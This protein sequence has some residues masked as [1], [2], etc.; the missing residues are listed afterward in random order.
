[1]LIFLNCYINFDYKCSIYNCYGDGNRDRDR[2][3]GRDRDRDRETERQRYRETDRQRDRETETERQRDRETERQRDRGTERQRNR[4][5]ERLTDRE[6]ERQTHTDRE[7]HRQTGR[8]RDR[9]TDR[10]THRQ[11]DRQT[12]RQTSRQ[13][14]RQ[15]GRQTRGFPRGLHFVDSLAGACN[16][17]GTP[18]PPEEL[19]EASLV[20]FTSWTHRPVPASSA[21]HWHLQ[22]SSWGLPL[23][24]S[25]RELTDRRLH[26]SHPHTLT[27]THQHTHSPT[28]P[29][30]SQNAQN[31]LKYHA[32]HGVKHITLI[33]K[34]RL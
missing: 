31:V 28:H 12:D 25:L 17:C 21:A 15:A 9:Q 18:A 27:P 34:P 30:I 32:F 14:D 7:T 10:Q 13:A 24:T 19:L 26:H 22:G 23:W 11:T 6:T 3:R 2:D 1:M 29:H 8:H 16:L 33:K 4:E 20:D 5:S